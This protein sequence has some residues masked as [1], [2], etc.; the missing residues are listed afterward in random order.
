MGNFSDRQHRPAALAPGVVHE[1]ARGWVRRFRSRAGELSASFRA[2]AIEL[3][4][5]VSDRVGSL[6]DGAL[7]AM[8]SAFEKARDL[9]GWREVGMWGFASVVSGGNL[10]ATNTSSPYLVVGRRRFMP[11]VLDRD[12]NNGKEHGP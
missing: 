11:P 1:T 6:A 12:E 4:G 5:E 2:L 3:G 10:I 9:P 8:A 7:S